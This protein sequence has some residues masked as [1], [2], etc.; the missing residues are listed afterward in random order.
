[1]KYL[2]A[3]LIVLTGCAVKADVEPTGTLYSA[4]EVVCVPVVPDV[5]DIP[6]VEP[7]NTKRV[8]HVYGPAWC[9]TCKTIPDDPRFIK[10]KEPFPSWVYALADR[11]GFPVMHWQAKGGA[12]KAKGGWTNETDLDA[13]IVAADNPVKTVGYSQ[14]GYPVRGSWWTHPGDVWSHLQQAPHN[15]SADYVRTLSRPE[16][17]S[18]H[19]DDHEHRVKGSPPRVQRYQRQVIR[20]TPRNTYCPTCPR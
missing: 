19:S 3:L 6:E 18:L 20:M 17:E 8:V 15:F 4:P 11:Q 16:A 7:V 1:M 5:P 10:H 2:S 12:W 14:K 9:L 13:A